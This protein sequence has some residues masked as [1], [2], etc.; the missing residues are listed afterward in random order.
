[1]YKLLADMESAIRASP[2][3]RVQGGEHFQNES[4]TLQNFVKQT[5]QHTGYAHMNPGMANRLD[6]YNEYSA[7]KLQCD[8]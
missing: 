2:M 6:E 1:M 3:S 4:F 5:L 7:V 8:E